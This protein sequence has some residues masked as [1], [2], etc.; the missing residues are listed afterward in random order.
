MSN[1]DPAD[2]FCQHCGRLIATMAEDGVQLYGH[3][4]QEL[5]QFRVKR[6][7]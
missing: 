6:S 2:Q 7:W 1:R 5:Q 3:R 4:C